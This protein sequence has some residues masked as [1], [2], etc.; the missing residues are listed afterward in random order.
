MAIALCNKKSK[1]GMKEKGD[2][3]GSN[4]RLEPFNDVNR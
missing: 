3:A 4:N 1:S 2:S